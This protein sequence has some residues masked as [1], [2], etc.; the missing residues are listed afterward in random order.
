MIKIHI[1]TKTA[2]FFDEKGE[3]F[4]MPEVARMLRTIANHL[5]AGDKV[6]GCNDRLRHRACTIQ[7]TGKDKRA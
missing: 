5:E 1:E 4:P 2:P 3:H 7:Y 6:D